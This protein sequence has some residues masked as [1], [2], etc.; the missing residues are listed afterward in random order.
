[1]YMPWKIYDTAAAAAYK[2]FA[3]HTYIG[4]IVQYTG[5]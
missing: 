4:S 5:I 2:I 3:I 1:M